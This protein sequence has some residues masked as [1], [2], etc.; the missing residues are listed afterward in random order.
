MQLDRVPLCVFFWN[1][2]YVQGKGRETTEAAVVRAFLI[3]G[4][5]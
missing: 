4:L 3:L 1:W 2:C 5:I